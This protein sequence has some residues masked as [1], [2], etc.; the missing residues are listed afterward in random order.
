MKTKI[1]NLDP[2][3]TALQT[4]RDL[5][6]IQQKPILQQPRIFLLQTC[7]L[8]W[9]SWMFSD[10]L[11]HRFLSLR[12]TKYV[13]CQKTQMHWNQNATELILV[14]LYFLVRSPSRPRMC[15]IH[16]DRVCCLQGYKLSALLV[17][18]L[19][20]LCTAFHEV[21][22]KPKTKAGYSQG[23][24]ILFSATFPILQNLYPLDLSRKLLKQIQKGP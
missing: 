13:I 19:F 17:N 8:K 22:N 16:S 14:L 7:H 3:T 20:L 21:W 12:F 23:T 18:T 10:L 15:W 5:K 9:I 1:H 2:L 4:C 11:S 24:D 6:W